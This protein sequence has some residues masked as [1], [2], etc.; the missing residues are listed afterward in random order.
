MTTGLER[1]L[2]IT[3]TRDQPEV[4]LRYVLPKLGGSEALLRVLTEYL[5]PADKARCIAAW[6]EH[7]WESDEP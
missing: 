6:T 1:S 5:S 2:R 7:K 3:P 4:V